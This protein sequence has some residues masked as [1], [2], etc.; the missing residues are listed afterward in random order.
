MLPSRKLPQLCSKVLKPSLHPAAPVSRARNSGGGNTHHYFR[1][2]YCNSR[3]VGLHLGI[4]VTSKCCSKSSDIFWS[5]GYLGSSNELS[6]KIWAP[7]W[8]LPL[9]YPPA[10]EKYY[11]H[12]F[13]STVGGSIQLLG[14]TSVENAVALIGT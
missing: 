7:K 12:N 13:I 3:F 10:T 2:A 4:S 5:K 9:T 8:Y 1:L 14:I 6:L 11:F